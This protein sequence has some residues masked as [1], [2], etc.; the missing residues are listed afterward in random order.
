MMVVGFLAAFSLILFLSRKI[1]LSIPMLINV[2]AVSLISGVV[3]TRL[4]FVIRNM[5]QFRGNL[6]KV[7][8]L[9]EGGFDLLGGTIL[10]I[11]VVFVYM[12]YHR[13]PVRHYLDILAIGFM[14][15]LV[16]GRM[17]CFLNGCCF[18]RPTSVPWAV[19]FPYDSFAYRSQANPGFN[20]ESSDAHLQLPADYF[21]EFGTGGLVRLKGFEELTDE[22]KEQVT[23]GQYRC[24]AVHPTQL[25]SSIGGAF[26]C[27]MLYLFWRRGR[28]DMEVKGAAKFSGKPGQ[29]FA[30][31]LIV[32][33]I[34]RFCMG[35]LRGDNP[36]E[37]SNS[38]LSV[39]KGWSI[40]Q[41]IALG[42][43]VLGVVMMGL[44]E[45]MKP[46]KVSEAESQGSKG[47]ED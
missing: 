28:K 27:C 40:S 42:M 4:F 8:A 10:T 24:I 32:Y 37:N 30:L 21:S 39:Y 33:G 23:S 9:W 11:S 18:G 6:L 36:F 2:S 13:L 22:Q 20:G 45:K 31:M 25:Y 19:R 29:S 15:F 16:F 1:G 35:F 26:L 38:W 5:D 43:V 47:I 44:F 17:G 46:Y 41:N 14:L 34:M 7:F 3:G 12:I